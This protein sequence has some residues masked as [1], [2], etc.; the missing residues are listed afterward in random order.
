MSEGREEMEM[1]MAFPFREKPDAAAA[2]DHRVQFPTGSLPHCRK[3][4]SCRRMLLVGGF[5]RESPVSPTL[6]F[7]RCSMLSSVTLI[8]SHDHT[9]ESRPD[10]LTLLKLGKSEVV[11]LLVLHCVPAHPPARSVAAR[12]GGMGWVGYVYR[13]RRLPRATTTGMNTPRTGINNAESRAIGTRDEEEHGGVLV[14]ER[15]FRC[16]EAA[17]KRGG[18]LVGV[19][20]R[21]FQLCCEEDFCHKKTRATISTYATPTWTECCCC[22]RSVLPG[23]SCPSRLAHRAVVVGGQDAGILSVVALLCF[24]VRSLSPHFRATSGHATVRVQLVT[25]IGD[26]RVN[27]E[28]KQVTA[29]PLPT[30]TPP[31][32]RN[33]FHAPLFTTHHI[34]RSH[35][36]EQSSIPGGLAPGLSHVGIVPDDAACRLVFSV[37]FRLPCHCI[38]ALLQLHTNLA[39]PTAFLKT[40]DKG[41]LASSVVTEINNNPYYRPLVVKLFGAPSVW[42]AAGCEF[43]SH[44]ARSPPR[45]SGFD[46]RPGHS[47][48]SHVRIVPD[49]AVGRRVFLGDYL[50]PPPP[51]APHSDAAPYS[52]QSPSS[53]LKTSMLRAST[54]S[55]ATVASSPAF[56]QGVPGFD[57][58]LGAHADFRTR[59]IVAYVA[60]GWRV[61]SACS[62]FPPSLY[63]G[64][65]GEEGCLSQIF[66][67]LGATL[68]PKEIFSPLLNPLTLFPKSSS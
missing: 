35:Q 60:I 61:S 6:L 41:Y 33:T 40:S 22:G 42:G 52:H 30:T 5:S 38:P 67:W 27:V 4:D 58:Q 2:T 21:R 55:F 37:I 66:A 23:R 15:G 50:S 59:E 62:H 18:E 25:C 34:T 28:S 54:P 3:W 68:F 26:G 7:Q 46:P 53:A 32:T 10:S 29:P 31:I 56:R 11:F 57:S 9:V 64:W 39:S 44:P 24:P 1:E 47:G 19:K 63:K 17:A 8:G 49:D 12:R 16:I 36:D 45:R 43:E 20:F 13:R 14:L 65:K 48:C 51:P